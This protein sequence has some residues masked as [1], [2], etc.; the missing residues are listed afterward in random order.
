MDRPIPTEVEICHDGSDPHKQFQFP[1]VEL[2]H[3]GNSRNVL[4]VDL[5]RVRQCR[6]PHAPEWARCPVWGV[7]RLPARFPIG[8]VRQSASFPSGAGPQSAHTNSFRIDTVRVRTV[9]SLADSPRAGHC[10][11]R[12]SPS[13]CMFPRVG[14]LPSLN[15]FRV[16]T[17][18]SRQ[19]PAMSYIEMHCG[20]GDMLSIS[21]QPRHPGLKISHV[22]PA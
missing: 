21:N 17:V 2:F 5:P 12:S 4:H 16:R 13:T 11:Q 22:H 20:S 18:R 10:P 8:S 1:E 19:A 15:V 7:A 3:V 14:R 9:R 6:S